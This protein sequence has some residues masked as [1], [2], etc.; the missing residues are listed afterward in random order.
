MQRNN[1]LFSWSSQ[2]MLFSFCKV[3]VGPYFKIILRHS[4]QSAKWFRCQCHWSPLYFQWSSLWI[5][6]RSGNKQLLN[7]LANITLLRKEILLS[8]SYHATSLMNTPAALQNKSDLASVL[9]HAYLC[10]RSSPS[11]HPSIPL[12]FFFLPSKLTNKGGRPFGWLGT[13][14]EVNPKRGVMAMGH[15]LGSVSPWG[16]SGGCARAQPP[17]KKADG[18]RDCTTHGLHLFAPIPLPLLPFNRCPEN[19]LGALKWK[20]VSMAGLSAQHRITRPVLTPAQCCL[21]HWHT[22]TH[23]QALF[24]FTAHPAPLLLPNKHLTACW[25]KPSE[26]KEKK[27]QTSKNT[28]NGSDSSVCVF[29]YFLGPIDYLL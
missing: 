5:F 14:A 3:L 12:L 29:P 20:N 2:H 27:P 16:V 26:W 21:F 17:K 22:F 1:V 19:P 25:Q 8:F 4:Y 24:M 6:F 7:R 10:R 11:I 28:Y 23:T 13:C 18:D 15:S 9:S